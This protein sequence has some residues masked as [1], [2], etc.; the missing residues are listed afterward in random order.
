MLWEASATEDAKAG[1]HMFVVISA[2]S[3]TAVQTSRWIS[4][5]PSSVSAHK[6]N[7]PTAF[8]R[9]LHT[10]DKSSLGRSSQDELVYLVPHLYV[11]GG[12]KCRSRLAFTARPHGIKVVSK[13]SVNSRCFQSLSAEKLFRTWGPDWRNRGGRPEGLV[14]DVVP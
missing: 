9:S 8:D 13:A 4:V 1:G 6:K 3:L 2:N 7:L 10:T 11:A 12:R 14:L 5:G